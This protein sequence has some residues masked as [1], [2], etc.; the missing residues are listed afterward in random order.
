MRLPYVYQ[1]LA[2]DLVTTMSTVAVMSG[3]CFCNCFHSNQT[4]SLSACNGHS[5]EFQRWRWKKEGKSSSQLDIW[6][7]WYSE[8]FKS[9]RLACLGVRK[10]FLQLPVLLQQK[11][12]VLTPLLLHPPLYSMAQ[13]CRLKLQ[14]MDRLWL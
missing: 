10:L 12:H 13:R 4:N 14:R 7:L 9:S 3:D 6:T 11:L 1:E 2:S 5:M 8:K